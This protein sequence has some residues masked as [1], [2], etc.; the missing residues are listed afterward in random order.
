MSL[1]QQ[2]LHFINNFSFIIC[3]AGVAIDWII[4]APIFNYY[5]EPRIE[6]RLNK[7]LQYLPMWRLLPIAGYFLCRHTEL[8]IGIA[9]VYLRWKWKGETNNVKGL[10]LYKAKY[11]IQDASKSEIVFACA[12]S[13][14]ALIVLIA[15]Q[16]SFFTMH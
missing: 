10:C 13:V 5:I 2:A 4:F 11:R 8:G 9:P 3:L 14:N 1:S 12:A 6:N 15:L 16:V 7:K